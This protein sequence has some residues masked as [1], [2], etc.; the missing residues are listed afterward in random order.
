LKREPKSNDEITNMLAEFAN[1]V[2]GN[3]CSILNKKNK[4][5]GLRVAPPSILVGEHMLI[6]PP[7][8]TTHTAIG[9]CVFGKMLLNVGF[10][11]S[12]ERWT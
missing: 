3:A 6:S 11:R 2:S 10:K 9:D 5:L 12:D 1:I 8:F 7:D 4:A